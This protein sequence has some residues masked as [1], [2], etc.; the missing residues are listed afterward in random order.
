[1]PATSL[2]HNPDAQPFWDGA[3]QHRLLLKRCTRCAQLHFPPRHLCPACWSD[4]LEW[5]EAS[6]KGSIYSH[7][8]VR[9]A[10]NAEFAAQGPYVLA[11][12]ALD[13]GPRLIT[14]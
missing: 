11:L 2:P 9:R 13:E 14:N 7:T 12:I 8:I 5:V 3:K 6:G 4:A 1:M 10:P